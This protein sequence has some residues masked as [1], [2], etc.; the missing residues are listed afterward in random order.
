[1]IKNP[2]LSRLTCVESSGTPHGSEARV[3]D[4]I[5]ATSVPGI[6]NQ[7]LP[8]LTLLLTPLPCLS[9]RQAVHAVEG[10][11]TVITHKQLLVTATFSKGILNKIN[12]ACPPYCILTFLNTHPSPKAVVVEEGGVNVVVVGSCLHPTEKAPGHLPSSLDQD[13]SHRG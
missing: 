9:L 7:D 2:K 1:M 12:E 5:P 6:S 4:A 3:L 10:C 11:Q 8:L 13:H